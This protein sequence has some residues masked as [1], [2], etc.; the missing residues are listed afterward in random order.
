[1][2]S[3]QL[4]PSRYNHFFQIQEGNDKKYMV[5]N[6]L[7]NGLAKVDPW[8]YDKLQNNSL[9]ADELENPANKALWG[10]LQSGSILVNADLNELSFVRFTSQLARFDSSTLTLTLVTSR[11]CNLA[12]SYCYE[13]QKDNYQT[14][15]A[16][17]NASVASPELTHE[18]I[19]GDEAHN[20]DIMEFVDNLTRAYHYRNLGVLWYGGEPLL[21]L[22]MIESLSQDLIAFCQTAQT[23]YRASLITNGTNFTKDVAL[24]L[25]E[26][27]VGFVQITVDGPKAVH[28]KRRP[29]KG[30]PDA[31]SF[32]T[33][34]ANLTGAYG[35]IPV[36]IRVNMDK[37]NVDHFVEL[38]HDLKERGLLVDPSALTVSFG[39]TRQV[40]NSLSSTEFAISVHQLSKELAKHGLGGVVRYP[41]IQQACSAIQLHNYVIEPDGMYHRCLETV[42]RVD[43]Y[44]G[45]ITGPLRVGRRALEWLQY[46]A[47]QISQECAECS[48]LPICGGGCPL[49]RMRH[50]ERLA[51]DPGYHCTSWKLF[52]QERMEDFLAGRAMRAEVLATK[53]QTQS[54]GAAEGPPGPPTTEAA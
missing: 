5:Y 44:L 15:T 20:D 34:I 49:F 46:D 17:N 1:M 45:N 2:P 37:S 51:A 26:L 38:L 3:V 10:S 7:S 9:T 30:R 21:N 19:L 27:Q 28:D 42:G 22:Q 52:L 54:E 16:D 25:K 24:R 41:E 14:A 11:A 32:D 40:C 4:R 43:E 13:Q 33:I 39:N 53:P 35:I 29:Y 47:T 50:Y 18:N 23:S 6:A 48:F 8:L 36:N 12:C 31:S